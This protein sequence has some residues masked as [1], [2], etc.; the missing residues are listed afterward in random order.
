VKE[1]KLPKVIQAMANV[2]QKNGTK[3][4]EV[5]RLVAKYLAMYNNDQK[6]TRRFLRTIKD[7]HAAEQSV[8]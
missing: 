8:N 2:L 6:A 4:A 1:Y 7:V 5:N 3:K